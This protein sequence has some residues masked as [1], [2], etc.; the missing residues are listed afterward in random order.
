MTKLS[1]L[2]QDELVSLHAQMGI[3]IP[4][5]KRDAAEALYYLAQLVDDVPD[6]DLSVGLR[7][8][9]NRLRAWAQCEC[10]PF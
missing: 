2:T 4:P 8:A 5:E 9:L 7:D 1:E 6:L 3:A 10:A